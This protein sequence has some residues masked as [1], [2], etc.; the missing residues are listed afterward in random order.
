M[1]SPVGGNGVF[2]SIRVVLVATDVHARA[3]RCTVV[4]A[5]PRAAANLIRNLRNHHN[6]LQILR[7]PPSQEAIP[8]FL[9]HHRRLEDWQ[10]IRPCLRLNSLAIPI[11]TDKLD[12]DSPETLEDSL[13][14]RSPKESTSPNTPLHFDVLACIMA[15]IDKRVDLLSFISTSSELYA[16]GLPFL[17]RFPCQ[18][19]Y[20][21]LGPFHQ[22]LTSKGP[23]SFLAL[24]DLKF[25]FREMERLSD[26]ELELVA[27]ILRKARHLR[28][29]HL[30]TELLQRCIAIAQAVASIAALHILLLDGYMNEQTS[31]A[32]SQL[33]SPLKRIEISVPG[34]GDS[35]KGSS[36]NML[37]KFRDTLESAAIKW[38]AFSPTDLCYTKITVLEISFCSHLRLSILV[39]AFPNLRTLVLGPPDLW[40][41]VRPTF[42]ELRA[43]NIGYQKQH[44][45][46]MWRLSELT[47]ETMALYVLALQMHVPSLTVTDFAGEECAWLQSTLATMQPVHLKIEVANDSFEDLKGLST[48]FS[49]G[50][51][52]LRRLN[53]EIDFPFEDFRRRE[54]F[55]ILLAEL[56]ALSKH[57]LRLAKLSIR[58]LF[59]Y[60][61]NE[62]DTGVANK[63]CD[64]SDWHGLAHDLV[65]AL[66]SIEML[67]IRAV[68]TKQRQWCW[69]VGDGGSLTEISSDQYNMLTM[70]F[71][72]SL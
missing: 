13:A 15:H 7:S 22:F 42:E 64:S 3:P 53:I 14:D 36:L 24:C 29:L 30:Q 9:R 11:M 48:I 38:D 61:R 56:N 45:G 50:T 44:Q 71:D 46:A 32:L 68:M 20:D 18:I 21:N 2:I 12:S 54:I 69:Q 39:P 62:E 4:P 33:H 25:T 65:I 49:G 31:L 57:T 52:G 6:H 34:F 72:N 67:D 40:T 17:L 47:A 35:S 26:S 51:E 55:G 16:S 70:E 1:L 43:E 63:V 23:R 8:R 59:S 19:S 37:G 66:P 10:E 60:I 27:Y 28:S 41:D 58:F 5:V